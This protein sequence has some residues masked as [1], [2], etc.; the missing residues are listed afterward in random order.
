VTIAVDPDDPE[1]V[2]AGGI[3]LYLST[4]GGLTFIETGAGNPLGDE[5]SVHVDQHAIAWEPGS[6]SNVWIGSDGGAWRSI[7]NGDTWRSRRD[8]LVTTQFYDVCL[9][10]NNPEF[11]MG[12]SQDNGLPWVEKAGAQWFPSTLLADG[13]ACFVEPLNPNTIHSEWQFG[14]HVRSDDRGWSWSP[15]VN[16][17]T[18]G[19]LAFAPLDLDPNRAGHL[20]TATFDGVFRTNNG[21][22]LWERV[23]LH[24]PTGLS[25]SPV[26]G[27]IVWTTVSLAGY[28][29]VRFTTDDGSTWIFTQPYGFSVGNETKILAHPNDPATVFITFAGYSGIAHLVRTK[30]F[31]QTWENV[32]GDFPPD[33]ANTMAI[34]P[35]NPSHW[36]VGTDTGVWYSA[37]EGVNWVPCGAGLPNVVVYDLEIHKRTR[38]LVACTYG[39]GI[40]SIDLP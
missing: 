17:L 24:S 9:D 28:P 15:K 8:G 27:D 21:Q 30:D 13:L 18:G 40:W 29:P 20:Y 33:P 5:D 6:S 22:D 16:G 26:D 19:S 1:R 12:G 31:G 35:I 3:K 39:R 2:I 11:I 32:S 23:A 10:S 7:D 36:F 34:D 37:N 4:N 38:K 14:G 25:I